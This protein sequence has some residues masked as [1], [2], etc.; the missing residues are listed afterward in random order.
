MRK[1]NGGYKWVKAGDRTIRRR[2]IWRKT[3]LFILFLLTWNTTT[4]E[5]EQI[6]TINIGSVPTSDKQHPPQFSSHFHARYAICWKKWKISFPIFVIFIF[7][8]IVKTHRKLTIFRTKMTKNYHIWKKKSEK[9]EIRFFCLL[10][11]YKY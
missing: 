7:R 4:I 5:R 3:Q 9:S 10:V 2:T 11:I 8:V 6:S 1:R